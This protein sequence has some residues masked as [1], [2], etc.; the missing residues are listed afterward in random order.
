[1]SRKLGVQHKSDLSLL[2]PDGSWFHHRRSFVEQRCII[3][4]ASLSALGS[5]LWNAVS[6]LSWPGVEHIWAGLGGMV[7]WCGVFLSHSFLRAI[8]VCVDPTSLNMMFMIPCHCFGSHFTPLT[9]HVRGDSSGTLRGSTDATPSA[10]FP[11]GEEG[12]FSPHEH[13]STFVHDPALLE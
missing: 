11:G 9:A 1:L 7:T 2:R 6:S 4:E 3:Y 12:D 8:R 5:L 10:L 13:R